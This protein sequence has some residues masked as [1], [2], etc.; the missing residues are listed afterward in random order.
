MTLANDDALD[1]IFRQARTFHHW[2]D[3]P[4]EPAMLEQ[5]WNLARLGPTAANSGP[6]RVLFIQSPAAKQRLKPSL[7]PANVDKTMSAPVTAVFAYS[8][9]FYEQL[10]KLFPLRDLR[11]GLRSKPEL[12]LKMGLQ[13]GT[14]GAA[15]FLLAAR[16]L[17]LDCGPMGGFHADLL[18]AEFFPDG[19][20]KALFLCNLGYG[21][22]SQLHPRLP[23]LDFSE[24]TEII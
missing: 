9:E 16:A 15:Y 4:V 24:A 5:I 7:D 6:L 20:T 17:G 23:R 19:K 14:L 22:R 12:A 11:P 2:Q 8:L 1:L 10:V 3:R 13:N 18:E 21:D